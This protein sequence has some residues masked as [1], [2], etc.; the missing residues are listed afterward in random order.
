MDSL[1]TAYWE[2]M[3]AG[4]A[5][6]HAPAK[7]VAKDLTEGFGPYVKQRVKVYYNSNDAIRDNGKS[8]RDSRSNQHR[9]IKKG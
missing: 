5:P 9:T 4:S 2:L 1:E 3:R 8:D 6:R 7:D